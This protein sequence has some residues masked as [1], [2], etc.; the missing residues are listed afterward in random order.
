MVK[1]A[2]HVLKAN[3][4]KLEGQVRLDTAQV[5]RG[6]PKGK[7]TPAAAPQVR[8]LENNP[9]FAVIEVTCSCGNK[10]CFKCEYATVESPV[11]TSGVNI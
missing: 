10:T 8:I 3:D 9:E 11:E 5:Q 4:V 1:L 2:G 7:K 6:L